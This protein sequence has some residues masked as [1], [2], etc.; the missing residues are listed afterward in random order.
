MPR[1][2]SHS[3]VEKVGQG[4]TLTVDEEA[5]LTPL[6]AEVARAR[7]VQIVRGARAGGTDAQMQMIRQVTQQ[8]VE[9][10]ADAD[11]AVLEAV[12][13]E[14]VGAL[15]SSPD[16]L[17]E[18][19]PNIDYCAMCVEQERSRHRARAVLTI[20]GRNQKGIVAHITSRIADFG[21][22][23]LD[24]SQT[25]VGNFFT[26]IIIVDAKSPS[27]PFEEFKNAVEKS[28]AEMGLGCMMMH[29]DVVASLHRV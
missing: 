22:D 25:L 3:E 16:G 7:N 11:P 15:E 5:I 12:I 6:A 27:V 17:V 2:I 13:G 21:G 9:K 8:V 24:I 14:V 20:T 1:V 4:G 19:G 23:I 18:V 28:V 10:M 26:M 29:E